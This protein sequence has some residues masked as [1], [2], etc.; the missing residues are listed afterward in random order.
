MNRA[1]LPPTAASRTKSRFSLKHQMC[2]LRRYRTS[3]F[4]LSRFVIFSP[5]YV[6]M[7]VFLAI[8]SL[9]KT[10]QPSMRDRRRSMAGR[11][12]VVRR[13]DTRIAILSAEHAATPAGFGA[14]EHVIVAGWKASYP[15]GDAS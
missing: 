5:S 13:R 14:T 3:R 12:D 2:P 8:G 10:P 6:T 7:R 1:M 9:A 4:R 11:E 15:R